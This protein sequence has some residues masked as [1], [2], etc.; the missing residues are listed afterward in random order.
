MNRLKSLFITP[1]LMGNMVGAGYAIY[2]LVVNGLHLGWLGVLGVTLPIT[3]FISFIMLFRSVAR[4]SAG[5][6]S[7]IA[8]SL[9]GIVL[10]IFEMAKRSGD[11]LPLVIT[12]SGFIGLMLYI[13]WYSKLVRSTGDLPNVGEELP[14]VQ[15]EKSDGRTIT[16]DELKGKMTLYLFFRGNWCPLCMAQIKEVAKQYQRLG[17]K[18]VEVALIS[19]QPHAFTE[20]LAHKFDV[21]F[22]F[23]VD[24]DGLAAK[25]L[26]I[27]APGGLPAGMQVMGYSSDTVLPTVIL[28]DKEGKILYLDQTDN[29]RVRPEPETFIKI[30]EENRAQ[31][32]P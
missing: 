10:N 31:Q 20:K 2:F 28:T 23:L 15:F 24:R 16:S 6:P 4:T 9:F 5:M 27:W 26:G 30:V 25:T 12:I 14:V 19:P 7:F 21:P 3:I 18:G 11:T 1:F 32:K 13:F 8:A 29:Y 22:L 17:D